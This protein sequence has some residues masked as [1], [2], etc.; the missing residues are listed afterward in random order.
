MCLTTWSRN[1]PDGTVGRSVL[2]VYF[3]DALRV[4]FHV[5][6]AHVE[7]IFGEADGDGFSSVP[8]VGQ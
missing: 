3:V 6:D 2:G 8:R 5:V 1:K 7:A 4:C